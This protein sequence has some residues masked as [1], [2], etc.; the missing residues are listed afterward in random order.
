MPGTYQTDNRIWLLLAAYSLFLLAIGWL[1]RRARTSSNSLSDF[2]LSARSMSLW[3]LLPTL[4]ATQYSGNTM[5]GFTAKAYRDGFTLLVS[6]TFMMAVIPVYLLYAPR[7]FQLSRQHEFITTADFIHWRFKNRLLTS[8]VSISGIIAMSNFIITNLKAIGVMTHAATG[9]HTPA[10]IGI[11]FFAVIIL[12]YETLG[13]LRSV[14][15]TDVIQG[16]VLFLGCLIIFGVVIAQA[17]GPTHLLQQIQSAAPQ[18]WTPPNTQA[19]IEWLSTILIIAIGI[20]LYPHAIQRI[21]AARSSRELKRALQI[22]VFLPLL[23]TLPMLTVGWIG[24]IRFPN[25]DTAAS[26]SITMNLLQTIAYENPAASWVVF[27]FL[28]AVFSAIMSTVDSALLS[29][30]SMLTQ[31]LYRP[32]RRQNTESQLS[33]F[34]T[35]SS[36]AVMAITVLISIFLDKSIFKII[37]IKLELLVQIAP[38]ILL[39]LHWPNLRPRP[40]LLGLIAGLATSLFFVLGSTFGPDNFIPRKPLGLHAGLV[41]L[42][43]N[44]TVLTLSQSRQR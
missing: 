9:G 14:A 11:T 21:Y 1:G 22:M 27:L 6:V 12:L 39:G 41:G 38:A 24:R 20:A 26:E 5:V 40:V 4:Y 23:T 36:I 44:L 3:V 15:W 13:G 10:W 30:S 8:L 2:Y 18:F 33:R 25:L 42:L 34:G 37:E 28:A 16:L 17:G 31:D 29:I 43:T 35:F 7:L 32:A 19:Q